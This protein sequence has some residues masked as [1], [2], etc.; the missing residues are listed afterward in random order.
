MDRNEWLESLKNDF[1]TVM[2]VVCG[3]VGKLWEKVFGNRS[4]AHP[5]EN[6]TGYEQTGCDTAEYFKEDEEANT[7]DEEQDYNGYKKYQTDKTLAEK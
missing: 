1:S 5:T 2:G 4:G 6:P 3:M 7:K